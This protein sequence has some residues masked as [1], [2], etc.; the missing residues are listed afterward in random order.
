MIF[1]CTLLRY[2]PIFFK[3]ARSRASSRMS[4]KMGSEENL[5]AM[6]S[7]MN[8]V[9]FDEEPHTQSPLVDMS[10]DKVHNS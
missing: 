4:S 8:D 5:P 1:T 6:A 9:V 2:I 10:H 3:I 7:M